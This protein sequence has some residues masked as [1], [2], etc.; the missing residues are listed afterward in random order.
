MNQ[1]FK[2]E[3]VIAPGALRV[4]QAIMQLS[5]SQKGVSRRAICRLLGFTSPNSVTAALLTLRRHGLVDWVKTEGRA[6]PNRR[7]ATLHATCYFKTLP[8][9][10]IAGDPAGENED[11]HEHDKDDGAQDSGHDA[12]A[13]GV[14][15]CLPEAPTAAPA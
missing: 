2:R 3:N 9:A 11:H 10:R 5:Q 1:Q 6:H 14:R 13:A 8:N 4:L 15:T 7:S 12:D